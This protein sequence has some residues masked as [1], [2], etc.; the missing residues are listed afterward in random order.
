MQSYLIDRYQ[1]GKIKNPCKSWSFS[2]YGMPQGSV[3]GSISFNRFLCYMFFIVDNVD[4]AS[5]ADDNIYLIQ[6]KNN[7]SKT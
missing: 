5:Y 6:Q 7:V 3:L 2:K 1:K 4:I